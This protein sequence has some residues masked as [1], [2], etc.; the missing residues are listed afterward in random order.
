MHPYHVQLHQ[1]LHEDDYNK[2][3]EFCRWA[4][5]QIQN[6]AYFFEYVLFGDEATFHK[7]G[8]VNRHNFHYYSTSN[9]HHI[10]TNSQT[11]WSLNVWA[12][13]LGNYVIGPYFFEDHLNGE[14]YLHFLDSELP[15]LLEEVPLNIRQKMWILHDGA[16]VH[17]NFLVN[18]HLNDS[19]PGRWIGRG[20][21]RRWPPRSP[22]LNKLDFFYGAI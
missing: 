12:G 13:I 18:E 22:G 10:L 2:R 8:N 16:P 9:P 11:R 21:P 19:F 15:E 4:Q 7:N 14:M 17:Y 5:E 6:N 3:V 1:E 20:G